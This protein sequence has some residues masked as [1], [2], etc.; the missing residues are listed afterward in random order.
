MGQ[1]DRKSACTF[2]GGPLSQTGTG[3]RGAT[4]AATAVDGGYHVTTEEGGGVHHRDTE[5]RLGAWQGTKVSG[6]G[7]PE[8]TQL[9]MQFP[10]YADSVRGK[11][12]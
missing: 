2:P 5:R 6:G 1:I 7:S 3:S 10:Q 4:I 8:P 12:G 9:H 11:G